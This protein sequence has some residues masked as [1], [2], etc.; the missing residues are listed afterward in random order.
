M[1]CPINKTLEVTKSL[2][3]EGHEAKSLEIFYS[4]SFESET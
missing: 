2:S 3:N 4:V 1:C